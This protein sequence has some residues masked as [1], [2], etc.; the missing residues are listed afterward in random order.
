MARQENIRFTFE[1]SS[2]LPEVIKQLQDINALIKEQ[3]AIFS[4][5]ATETNTILKQQIDNEKQYKEVVKQSTQERK[6]AAQNAKDISAQQKQETLQNI[7]AQ[8]NLTSAYNGQKGIL[9]ELRIQLKNYK[10]ARE[11][12]TDPTDVKALTS[13]IEGTQK[14][15]NSLTGATDKFKGSNGFWRDMKSMLI[16]AFAVNEISNFTAK[17]FDAQSKV[18]LFKISVNRLFGEVKGG[19]LIEDLKKLIER[20]PLEFEKATADITNLS[21]AYKNLGL[22][23]K[24]LVKDYEALGNA[25]KGNTE[26]LNRLV[27]VY[28]QVASANKLQGNDIKQFTEAQVPIIQLL[29][30][31]LG[32]TNDEI[33]KMK[34]DGAITFEMVRKALLDASKA[35]GIFENAMSSA[36]DTVKGKVSNFKDSIFFALSNIGNLFSDDAK[37]SIDW[38]TTTIKAMFGTEEATKRT[39]E[40]IKDL[41]GTFLYYNLVVKSGAIALAIETTAMDIATISHGLLLRAKVLLTGES[42]A[43]TEAMAAEVIASKGATVA[44]DVMTVAEAE[45]I[46]ATNG[47]KA[48]FGWLAIALG[49]AYTAY[50]IYSTHVD[51][52]KNKKEELNKVTKDAVIPLI[53]EKEQF[54]ANAKAVLN[55]NLSLNERNSALKTLKEQYPSNMKGINSLTDADEK[56]GKVIKATNRDFEIRQ[57]LMLAEAYN[58]YNQSKLTDLVSK[59]MEV[60]NKLKNAQKN[61]TLTYDIGGNVDIGFDT[62]AI[63]KY[64]QELKAIIAQM[65]VFTGAMAKNQKVIL[66]Q[67]DLLT[68]KYEGV[69]DKIKKAGDAEGKAGKAR[70]EYYNA[71][72]LSLKELAQ[73]RVENAEES[74]RLIEETNSKALNKLKE[75]GAGEIELL[76]NERVMLEQSKAYYQK[77]FDAKKSLLEAEKVLALDKAKFEKKSKVDIA[78]INDD[79]NDR[80]AKNRSQLSDKLLIIA[81]KE[82]DLLLK[83]RK[84]EFETE[85]KYIEDAQQFALD[86]FNSRANDIKEFLANKEV[87]TKSAV[88]L[89]VEMERELTLNATKQYDERKTL[90]LQYTNEDYA[91]RLQVLQDKK[92]EAQFE[93]ERIKNDLLLTEKQKNEARKN[94]IANIKDSEKQ[95]QDLTKSH[96]KILIQIQADAEKARLQIHSQ[97]LE[98]ILESSSK[99]FG[100]LS[101]Y[102]SKYGGEE[103]KYAAE[104]LKTVSEGFKSM[105]NI[106]KKNYQDRIKIIEDSQKYEQELIQRG[107]AKEEAARQANAKKSQDLQV[108]QQASII[109][110]VTG[111]MESGFRLAENLLKNHYQN[112]LNKISNEVKKEQDLLQKN[113]DKQTK[114]LEDSYKKQQDDLKAHYDE[115]QRIRDEAYHVEQS[116]IDGNLEQAKIKLLNSASEQ[117]SALISNKEELAKVNTKYDHQ[118]LVLQQAYNDALTNGTAEQ[119]ANAGAILA[120]GLAEVANNRQKDLANLVENGDAKNAV[121]EST[122]N[123]L[124]DIQTLYEGKKLADQQAYDNKRLADQKAYDEQRIAN[125]KLYN[126][127]KI[128]IEKEFIHRKWELS[129]KQFEAEKANRLAQAKIE[130]LLAGLKGNIFDK[131]AAFFVYGSILKAIESEL[132][133]PEPSFR[134]G[135]SRITDKVMGKSPDGRTNGYIAE[136]HK[137][138]AILTAEQ[139]KAIG[140]IGGERLVKIVQEHR[141]MQDINKERVLNY[142]TTRMISHKDAIFHNTISTEKIES[143]L[144]KVSTKLDNV[145]TTLSNL[146]KTEI[147]HD[148]R[149]TTSRT[150]TKNRIIKQIGNRVKV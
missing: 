106:V 13:A 121:L 137:D 98:L 51:A 74:L 28:G 62:G 32:K 2:Q 83:V 146:P 94:E 134:V 43:L 60:Q 110:A 122:E 88:S 80:I 37:I 76:V 6:T 27:Y 96:N 124:W 75:R 59:R 120:K 99:S 44:L 143:L 86:N 95:I 85:K 36:M 132:P 84:K 45:A 29:E 139:N 104:S 22:D 117:L 42:I 67:T 15:I 39:V 23:S 125:D 141:I 118:N 92:A 100:E 144:A 1:A 10:I 79:Y 133:P 53:A 136:V 30:Q 33:L 108:A 109:S 25:A 102:L 52:A 123:R 12:A 149:G 129:V 112:K 89:E 19:A 77:D 41:I 70:K 8:L 87:L 81:E 135:T 73:K 113:Y 128:Q 91:I 58:E 115:M 50:D 147:N 64:D 21:Y 48:S 82:T 119:L 54:N 127:T 97:A 18:E 3:T 35:G 150:I 14:Q 130:V 7:A 9:E 142:N 114:S 131:V 103:K 68:Y 57:R 148:E 138:E 111:L 47:L 69:N 56:L 78:E 71:E 105:V 34:S 4:N 20:S 26:V 72:L 11:Q 63:K 145:N 66:E 90:L 31:S 126:D 101:S 116:N 16:G 24:T 46:V 140:Y 38:A 5:Y 49:L 17:I 93:I 107:V 40:V 55:G 65:G 61:Q